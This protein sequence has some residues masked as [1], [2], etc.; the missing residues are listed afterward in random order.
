MKTESKGVG[1]TK[2]IASA[3]AVITVLLTLVL[4]LFYLSGAGDL[5]SGRCSY[6]Q[7]GGY[8]YETY[9]VC[10]GDLNGMVASIISTLTCFPVAILGLYINRQRSWSFYLPMM[11]MFLASAVY[12]LNWYEYGNLLPNLTGPNYP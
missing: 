2:R 10:I 8:V 5:N 7:S 9:P 6:Y 11:V 1:F 4:L 3:L 12:A